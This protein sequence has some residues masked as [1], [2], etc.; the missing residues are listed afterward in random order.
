[1]TEPLLLLVDDAREMGLIV[2]R[3]AARAGCALEHCPDAYSAWDFLRAK[4]PDLLLLD[5]NLV[6]MSGPELCRR[7]RETPGLAALP[8]AVFTHEGLSDDVAAGLEAGA[9]FLFPK[10][11]VLS[12]EAW[13]TRLA[14]ILQTVRSRR[15]GM[16]L[17][18]DEEATHFP[19]PPDWIAKVNGALRLPAL[20][21]P[22]PP[23]V[24]V[25]LRRALS[26]VF[27]PSE[28]DSWL[29]SDGCELDATR[30]PPAA[31]RDAIG[32]ADALAEQ[33]WC[34]LGSSAGTPFR[35]V[36]AAAFP[37]LSEPLTR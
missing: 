14:E 33:V 6:G 35:G 36:L 26:L 21:G 5:V 28:T 30:V 3:L 31:A 2:A 37:G 7:V 15:A 29:T 8:V 18:W 19:V 25:L 4:V 12:P 1:M 27:G 16:P 32:L 17:R 22:G 11:L 34:V 24:R 13:G 9:D 20:R 10:D 23:V